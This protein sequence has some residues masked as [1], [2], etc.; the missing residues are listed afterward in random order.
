MRASVLLALSRIH[1]VTAPYKALTDAPCIRT[2]VTEGD[3][4]ARTTKQDAMAIGAAPG[5]AVADDA[6]SADEE[7]E[8]ETEEG[9]FTCC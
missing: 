3:E 6:G 5:R 4:G 7:D 9:T 8:M 1:T 2:A